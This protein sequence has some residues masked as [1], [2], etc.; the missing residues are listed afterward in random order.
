M[1]FDPNRSAKVIVPLALAGWAGGIAVFMT[2]V[3]AVFR[4]VYIVAFAVAIPAVVLYLIAGTGWG[5]LAR[6]YRAT[7]PFGGDWQSCPTGQMAMVSFDHPDFDKARMRFIGGS[8]RVAATA[9]ALHLT[10]MV[11]GLPVL[12]RFFPALRI[13]WG[14]VS[15]AHAFEAPGWVTPASEPGA[16]LRLAYDPNYTGTFIEMEIG[17]PAVYVQLPAPM[18]GEGLPQLGLAP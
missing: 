5:A 18:L 10:T 9:D 6:P 1:R 11:S 3:P 8:L 7:V 12:R 2:D 13:P 4:V 15:R 14:D 17:D 16:L